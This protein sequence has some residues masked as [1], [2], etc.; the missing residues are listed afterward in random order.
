M[1]AMSS[2]GLK[3]VAFVSI[4][5]ATTALSAQILDVDECSLPATPVSEASVVTETINVTETSNIEEAGVFLDLTHT[6]QGDM[7]I[8][9]ASPL[10]TTITLHDG[11]GSGDDNILLNYTDSGVAHGADS[12]TCNCDMQPSSGTFAS[13]NGTSPFGDWELVLT[14]QLGGDSGTLNE[15][16]VRLVLEEDALFLRGDVDGNGVVG[17]I[18]D[19]TALLNWQ[20]NLGAAPPCD[21]AADCNDDGTISV[22]QDV[23]FLLTWQFLGGTEPP[24]P[25]T[26][27]CDVDGTGDTLRCE[28]PPTC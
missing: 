1:R 25:G 27:T 11:Q 6:F 17:A 26:T 5:C 3:A 21:D 22:L 4:L 28:T 15:W 19:A 2:R 8:T 9:V 23:I 24:A 16:C 20:F 18:L 10:G 13:Y 7:L 14:D 12:F